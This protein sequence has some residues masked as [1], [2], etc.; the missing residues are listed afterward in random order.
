MA[1]PASLLRRLARLEGTAT[2]TIVVLRDVTR[3]DLPLSRVDGPGGPWLR[4][5][6]EDPE[7]LRERALAAVRQRAGVVVLHLHHE[8][9]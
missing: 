9:A 7:C 6:S 8:A 5:P 4:G 3:E 2:P 1:V